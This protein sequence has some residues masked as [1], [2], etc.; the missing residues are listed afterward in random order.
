MRRHRR[1]RH[2]P[3]RRV[4]RG[5]AAQHALLRTLRAPVADLGVA[6]WP[7]PTKGATV[8]CRMGTFPLCMAVGS[9]GNAFQ[10]R[11]R[12]RCRS[13]AG[14]PLA[15]GK[16]AGIAAA[17]SSCA[18]TSALEM[19]KPLARAL[20]VPCRHDVLHR[21][22]HT[23]AQTGLDAVERRRNL[24]AAFALREDAVLPAHVAILDD[25]FTTGTTLSECARVLK[26]AGVERVDVWAL[27][28]APMPGR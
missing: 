2:R 10:I 24:R 13:C 22:R 5:T 27:A 12:P 3:L 25:V 9:T 17:D 28:R 8:G 11:A 18:A 6:M 23:D 21:L 14:H 26:R 4:H 19:A 15:T 16:T 7:L 1:G 20:G